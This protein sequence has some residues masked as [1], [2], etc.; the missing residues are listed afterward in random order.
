MQG[1]GGGTPQAR[2]VKYASWRIQISEH[3]LKANKQKKKTFFFKITVSGTGLVQVSSETVLLYYYFI[4]ALKK[5]NSFM[6]YLIYQVT[7]TKMTGY[8]LNPVI[9]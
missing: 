1:E 6:A 4:I 5:K 9:K 8:K 3:N 2:S 7:V